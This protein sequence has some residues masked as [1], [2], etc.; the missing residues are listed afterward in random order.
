MRRL[1]LAA[2]LLAAAELHAAHPLITEDTGT[3]GKGRWQL[4]A[5][6]ESTRNDE[7]G[8]RVRGFQ[9]AATLSY[10]LAQNVDLQ[11]TQPWLRGKA[12]GV[13]V[14]GPL[15]SSIDV[16]WR[17]FEKAALSVALKPGI[18]LA[19]GDEAKGLGAGRAGW[20]TLLIFSYDAG[21]FDF[22]AHAG[23]RR[24]R[25]TLGERESLSHFSAA[26]TYDVGSVKLIADIARDTNAAPAATDGERYAVLGAIWSVTPGF[27]LDIGLKTGHKTAALDRA[28]LFGATWRW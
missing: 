3:Q 6:A 13:V 16:K 26:L 28:L 15:D 1:G 21:A 10:G 14:Q 25:N 4:E 27:D 20:G 12:A 18:T 8:E 9:P 7:A 19:T 23:Y 11:L 24:N 22:H 2:C 5:N 17:F